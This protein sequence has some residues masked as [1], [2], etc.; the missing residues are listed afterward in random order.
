MRSSDAAEPATC[1]GVRSAKK[2]GV[3]GKS[4][5]GTASMTLEPLFGTLAS[6]QTYLGSCSASRS[7]VVAA[8]SVIVGP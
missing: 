2:V 5:I 6:N 3:V 8:E 7:S 4:I 1:F